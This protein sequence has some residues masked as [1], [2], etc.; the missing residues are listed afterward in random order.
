M[1]PKPNLRVTLSVNFS[2]MTFQSADFSNQWLTQGAMD[3]EYKQY[4]FLAWM[5]GVHRH[6]NNGRVYPALSEVIEQHRSLY[7]LQE[8]RL[9]QLESKTRDFIGLDWKEMKLLFRQESTHDEFEAYLDTC[10]GFAIPELDRALDEGRD[11]F[12]FVEDQI[13]FTPIG[14]VP[15][16]TNDGYLVVF[17][18]SQ[19]FLRT[20]RYS[21]SWIQTDA[22]RMVRIAMEPVDERYKRLG[23]SIE[24]IK[25]DLMKR[26]HDLPNPA[27]FLVRATMGFPLQETLL[28]IAKRMLLRAT[29]A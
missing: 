17:D 21:K 10:L 1:K 15:L 24:K 6:F 11:L 22:D 20:Y 27:T 29:S 28:P 13:E 7:A 23:E 5:Q 12:D 26:F 8:A 9:A 19:H 18:E 4:L 3:A 16:Y 25:M 14:L 2:E